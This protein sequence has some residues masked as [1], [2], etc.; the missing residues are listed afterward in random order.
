V[1]R[2][3]QVFHRKMDDTANSPF[4]PPPLAPRTRQLLVLGLLLS[5]VF[6]AAAV[7]GVFTAWGMTPDPTL[8][9]QSFYQSLARP[10][11]NPPSWVFG[12]VWTVLYLMMALA[13]WLLYR[14]PHGRT[15]T[16][17]LAAWTVQLAA[18]VAWSALFFGLRR[19]ALALVD[20]VV[21]FALV[22]VTAALAWRVRRGA[23]IL[24]LPYLGWIAFA[25][26]LN[27]EIVRLNY[28]LAPAG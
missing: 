22:A 10:T 19:P 28:A 18:N 26:A 20:I 21:L 14:A 17:A 12:P 7:G 11:W 13:A 8:G 9:G 3:S 2:I 5:L 6:I 1:A 15:R 23:G 16:L 25:T 24:L 4:A 27:F